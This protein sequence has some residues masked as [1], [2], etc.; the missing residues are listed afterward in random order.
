MEIRTRWLEDARVALT[1]AG[2]LLLVSGGAA[3]AVRLLL[4]N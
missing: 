3:I 4:G 2:V 1:I